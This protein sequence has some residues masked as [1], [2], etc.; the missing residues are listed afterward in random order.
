MMKHVV[1][2]YWDPRI[3]FIAEM[4]KRVE[5]LDKVPDDILFDL[6]FSMK[7]EYFEKDFPVLAKN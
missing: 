7:Y 6:I 2:N 4:I 1:K 5:Y 3:K